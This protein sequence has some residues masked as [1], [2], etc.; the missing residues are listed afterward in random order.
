MLNNLRSLS[1]LPLLSYLSSSFFLCPPLY[2]P[3]HHM[4]LI[5]L[6]TGLVQASAFPPKSYQQ[7]NCPVT[8]VTTADAC[9]LC[10]VPMATWLYQES[11]EVQVE[12]NPLLAHTP[13]VLRLPIGKGGAW[14]L[15]W[16]KSGTNNADSHQL[17]IETEH[18]IYVCLTAL[19][20]QWGHFHYFVRS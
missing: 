7:N 2:F 17:F 18:N 13:S 11:S 1:D 14:F 16:A 20:L 10:T 12:A 5:R 6:L 8:S 15:G 3:Q 4:G 19:R 9:L